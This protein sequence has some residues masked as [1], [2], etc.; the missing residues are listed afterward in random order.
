MIRKRRTETSA[1]I[2]KRPS[3]AITDSQ[4][5]VVSYK[6]HKATSVYKERD[7]KSRAIC[8]EYGTKQELSLG[9][10]ILGK[11]QERSRH[12]EEIPSDKLGVFLTS[13][14]CGLLT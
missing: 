8:S 4:L 12:D 3:G 1:L 5:N 14:N 6:E 11:N 13:C 7:L 2:I 10:V 9:P